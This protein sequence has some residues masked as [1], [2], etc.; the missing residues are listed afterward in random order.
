[1]G[2][3]VLAALFLTAMQGERRIDRVQVVQDSFAAMATGKYVCAIHALE[4]AFKTA[5]GDDRAYI[6]QF[7]AYSYSFVGEESKA[8]SLMDLVVPPSESNHRAES[9]EIHGAEPKDAIPTIVRAVKDHQIV[10]LNESHLEPRSRAFALL[11]ARELRKRGF[12]F[13][14]AETFTADVFN[15]WHERFP[16]L[17]MGRY[18]MEPFFGDLVRQVIALG[19][20]PMNYEAEG[21]TYSG[22]WMDRANQRDT[23]EAANIVERI[24]KPFPKAKIFIYCGGDHVT[25]DWKRQEDGRDLAWMAARLKKT[26][27]IDPLTIDQTEEVQHSSRLAESPE[28]RY[29]DSHGWL[30]R[31]V[32]LQLSEGRFAVCG[33]DFKNGGVDMQVFHPR[34]AEASGPPAW[35]TMGG[36]RKRKVLNLPIARA[37]ELVQAFVLDEPID[38]VPMDQVLVE[39]GARVPPLMLPTGEYRIVAQ[40]TNGH[41]TTL[42]EKVK[43]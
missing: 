40:G 28:Y 23:A 34:D 25:E 36:Y 9:S 20:K 38:S 4:N 42:F 13:L 18:T 43:V 6:G 15:A 11:L 17:R 14:A 22:D 29:A 8:E 7:L 2:F 31:P 10:I 33:D 12:E 26:T 21:V 37:E 32:V 16:T 30:N 35:M 19:Y 39:S 5:A 24:L 41:M 3:G 27:G 1:V